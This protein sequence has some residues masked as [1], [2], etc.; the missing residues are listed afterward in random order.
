MS[1]Q[2]LNS[3][4]TGKPRRASILELWENARSR[5]EEHAYDENNDI[6]A[7]DVLSPGTAR[8]DK[9]REQRQRRHSLNRAS[10]SNRGDENTGDSRTSDKK[11][12]AARRPSRAP[13]AI[14]GQMGS[15]MMMV[16]PTKTS[17]HATSQHPF[18]PKQQQEERSQQRR[19]YGE[20]GEYGDGGNRVDE[21]E[22]VE[23]AVKNDVDVFSTGLSAISAS[24]TEGFKRR[25][26]TD[27]L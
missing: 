2:T 22:Y 23:E 20:F 13:P 8:L 15:A 26:R 21:S 19:E 17:P 18:Q 11:P 1:N 27:Y 6:G 25:L 9:V 24:Q 14:P 4:P 5:K 7:S 3:T 12:V 16:L 10:A